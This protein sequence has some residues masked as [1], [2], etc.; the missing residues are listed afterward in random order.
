MKMRPVTAPASGKLESERVGRGE[1]VRPKTPRRVQTSHGTGDGQGVMG[2]QKSKTARSGPKPR[3]R[4]L[5]VVLPP[6][7]ISSVSSTSVV[8]EEVYIREVE[9]EEVEFV[10]V[11][12]LSLHHSSTYTPH[13]GHWVKKALENLGS[14]WVRTGKLT[15]EQL[16]SPEFE[17]KM[18]VLYDLS[19][20]KNFEAIDRLVDEEGGKI[21]EKGRKK[22]GVGRGKGLS[23]GGKKQE[24]VVLG[25]V[26]K[27]FPF[28]ENVTEEVKRKMSDSLFR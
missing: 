4:T 17:E 15:V 23:G 18:G 28:N 19:M 20:N 11:K 1:V 7:K 24:G 16:V 13:K 8:D 12:I 14:E 6:R 27:N 2:S 25:D 9:D 21:G 10:P 26:Q 22:K 5:S 3:T